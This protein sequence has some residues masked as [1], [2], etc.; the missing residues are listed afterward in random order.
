MSSELA[1][2]VALDLEFNQPSRQII[3]IGAVVA[4][5]QRGEVDSG[6]SCL[7]NP[8]EPLNPSV[9]A[10]TGINP[11]VIDAAPTVDDAYQ[12]MGTWLKPY[13][14]NR[15]L[16]PLVWGNNISGTLCAAIGLKPSDEEWIFS[17][18]A[19]NV[20]QFYALF[21]TNPILYG[22]LLKLRLETAL[23]GTLESSVAQ[24]GLTF[25]GEPHNAMYRAANIFRLYR[26][27]LKRPQANA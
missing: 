9:A 16:V 18:K 23:V 11:E 3:Q 8:G 25:E 7:V 15:S 26:A 13:E 4:D 24:F 14:S 10:L 1:F 6:F 19:N 22:L 21:R 2:V 17:A 5:L 27:L 12:Q 20:K